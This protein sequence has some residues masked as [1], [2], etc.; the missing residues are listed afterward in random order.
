MSSNDENK[1]R[2]PGGQERIFFRL[3]VVWPNGSAET[4]DVAQRPLSIGRADECAIQ[5]REAKVSRRHCVVYARGGRLHLQDQGSANGTFVNGTKA[6][7]AQLRPGD[8]LRVGNVPIRVEVASVGG[9]Y[10]V[11]L[12]RARKSAVPDPLDDETQSGSWGTSNASFFNKVCSM[13]AQATDDRAAADAILE[14]LV[15]LTAVERAFFMLCDECSDPKSLVT[16]ATRSRDKKRSFGPCKPVIEQV[17]SQ[18]KAFC[19]FDV[20]GDT[21]LMM[22]GEEQLEGIAVVLCAPIEHDGELIGVMYA[23]ASADAKELDLEVMNTFKTI[24]GQSGTVLGCARRHTALT[25]RNK[26]LISEQ[27]RLRTQIFK[28]EKTLNDTSNATEE[29]RIDILMHRNELETLQESRE[30]AAL[31]LV[32]DMRS[33]VDAVNV[34]LAQLADIVESNSGAARSVEKIRHVSGRT[35]A[36]TEDMLAVVQMENGTYGLSTE[37]VKVMELLGAALERNRSIALAIGVRLKLG[38]IEPDLLAIADRNVVARVLDTF[39][40][41]AL[42]ATEHGAQITLSARDDGSSVELVVDSL[43]PGSRSSGS[44]SVIR[45]GNRTSSSAPPQL[46]G[47]GMLYCRLAADAHGGSVQYIAGR[48]SSRWGLELPARHEKERE[49]TLTQ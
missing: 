5:I 44:W 45:K 10:G 4:F 16:I 7:Q 34:N 36:L 2:A 11:A 30:N 42:S 32:Q 8:Q 13:M 17:L 19:T 33:M 46:H 25:D 26:R 14:L 49:D 28:L 9:L 39:L 3:V 23:D 12:Q 22:L 6:A 43:L 20:E 35:C 47:L 21:A 29:Q 41:N 38:A 48:R 18:Q 24:A 31:S 40:G 27:D 1:P 15:D 37:P